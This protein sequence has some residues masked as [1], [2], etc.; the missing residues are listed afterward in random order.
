[1]TD[2]AIL[3][4][5]DFGLSAV[6]FAS[7]SLHGQEQE[8]PQ[9][10]P[11]QCDMDRGSSP[12]ALDQASTAIATADSSSTPAQVNR[13]TL[14]PPKSVGFV[15]H[16]HQRSAYN[17]RTPPTAPPLPP[18]PPAIP[19]GSQTAPPSHAHKKLAKSPNDGLQQL[20]PVRRLKSVVGSPHYIAPEI[21]SNGANLTLLII[22]SLSQSSPSS[23]FFII[24]IIIIIVPSS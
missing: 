13:R 2:E 19:H 14:T 10:L 12:P 1:M 3:K 6:V 4:I 22:N 11:V 9:R 5:A 20:A 17:L 24:I 7:E 16:P 23:S 21:A 8:R 15:D 18:P